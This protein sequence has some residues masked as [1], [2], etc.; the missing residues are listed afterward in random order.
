MDVCTDFDT[1]FRGMEWADVVSTL[2]DVLK[3]ETESTLDPLPSPPPPPLPSNKIVLKQTDILN[4]GHGGSDHRSTVLQYFEEPSASEVYIGQAPMDPEPFYSQNAMWSHDL[5]NQ[6]ALCNQGQVRYKLGLSSKKC[7]W[8]EKGSWLY[9]I[10]SNHL[11]SV[12]LQYDNVPVLG[13]PEHVDHNL[14][15]V[16]YL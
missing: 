9:C 5:Y 15:P 2:E 6:E 14:R 11:S 13:L 4:G 12:R 7:Y 10:I 8:K 16:G 1:Y 3:V